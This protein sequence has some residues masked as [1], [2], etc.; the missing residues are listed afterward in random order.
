MKNFYQK[1]T[2]N[3]LLMSNGTTQLFGHDRQIQA[4]K[5]TALRSISLL[6]TTHMHS[7]MAAQDSKIFHPLVNNPFGFM[8]LPEGQTVGFNGERIDM[9][10]CMYAL[11]QG[12]RWYST[13][14]M[15]FASTDSVSPF[16]AGGI[17]A[18]AY[19]LNDPVNHFDPDGHITVG[20]MIHGIKM[21]RFHRSFEKLIT[22]DDKFGVYR[23]QGS[24]FKKPK[25]LVYA[26]GNEN[27]L[28]IGGE[29]LDAREFTDWLH[30][31]RINSNRYRKV[32]LASCLSGLGFAQEFANINTIKVKAAPGKIDGAMIDDVIKGRSMFGLLS[33]PYEGMPKGSP[34]RPW[35]YEFE[36]FTPQKAAIRGS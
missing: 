35:A 5:A 4:I 2:L 27:A 28:N 17:N 36:R 10:S 15:R 20:P 18:Y 1:K 8:S 29:S 12:Y 26:H 33:E 25:L 9:Q 31:N 23:S 7:P 11:G 22:I 13:A 3:T 21:R 30:Q 34:D 24:L 19:A 32:V 14:L 6:A 16:G